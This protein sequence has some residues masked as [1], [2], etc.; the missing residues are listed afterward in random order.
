[1]QGLRETARI[2]EPNFNKIKTSF[3]EEEFKCLSPITRDQFRD[4]YIYCDPVPETHRDV[5][6]RISKKNL[7]ISVQT[8]SRF[9]ERFSKGYF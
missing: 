7:D 2:D 9:I 4:L 8:S 6:R 1:L 3:T 5:N